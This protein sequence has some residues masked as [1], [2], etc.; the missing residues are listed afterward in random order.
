MDPSRG[1][2]RPN[3]TPN[4]HNTN[5]RY[6]SLN[7]PSQ[8]RRSFAGAS[9]RYRPAPLNTSPSTPARGMGAT[10]S[11]SE[12]YQQPAQAGFST[13]TSLPSATMGYHQGAADYG[14]D[15]RQ[16]QGYASA[17][18]TAMMYNVPPATN[19][20]STAVYDASGQ[21]FTPR[22]PAGMPMMTADVATP[23]FTG[24]QT[25]PAAA[26]ALQQQTAPSQSPAIYQ[27]SP[28]DRNALLQSYSSGMGAMGGLA[29]QA[30]SSA[31]DVSME[32]QEYPAGGGLDEAYA[33]Y[34]SA[35]KE[36][37]QNIK[38]STLATASESVLNVSD[39]LL[40]HV[41]ELGKLLTFLH[42]PI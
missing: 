22:Q 11:Y 5:P 1:Q 42:P 24:D 39:W 27:Q 30:P 10:A 36:I 35:L 33:S 19:T 38:S 13:A 37:F 6:Q 12:Y 29:S 21:T 7:D 26:S 8:Q 4:L 3:E 32:E 40:S 2:R 23:Y 31:A 17:Y 20:Q 18:N 34:Q 14:Q 41:V 16:S 15:A 28:A 9:D 25:N